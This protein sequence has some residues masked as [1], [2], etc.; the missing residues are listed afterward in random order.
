MK[1]AM[2]VSPKTIFAV[3]L[4][5]LGI[6][7]LLFPA[8]LRGLI[9]GKAA[10]GET[11]QEQV[12]QAE[13]EQVQQE[14]EQQ[15]ATEESSSE[16]QAIKYQ[17]SQVRRVYADKLNPDAGIPNVEVEVLNMPAKPYSREDL[18]ETARAPNRVIVDEDV[19]DSNGVALFDGGAIVI[20]TEYI[21]ALRNGTEWYDRLDHKA[22]PLPAKEFKIDTY[23]FPER[24][25]SYAIGSF[26]DI[27]AD[28]D[29]V[30]ELNVTGK[31]GA[32][33]R[34]IDITIE[35]ADAGAALL[36]PVIQLRSKPGA[37]PEAG[38]FKTLYASLKEGTNLGVP[39]SDLTNFI[40]KA[41]MDLRGK[42][43]KDLGK[44]V[45]TAAHKAVYTLAIEWDADV[46]EPGTSLYIHLDDLGEYRGRSTV[47]QELGASTERSS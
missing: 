27:S 43:D 42:F 28:A 31:T 40:D 41:P 5:A 20:D 7:A 10:Q 36:E 14:Q 45:M 46:A 1:G 30:I 19:T 8:Q 29:N 38:S 24:V 23:R 3:L 32:Q 12:Q 4:V 33:M 18:I 35:Q 25:L 44:N 2:K 17:L 15:Q 26:A 16:Q 21:Y 47:A 6:G 34:R 39:E 9:T 13:E 37:E 22:I 11:Q